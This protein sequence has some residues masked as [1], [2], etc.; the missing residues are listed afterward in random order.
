ME[1]FKMDKLLGPIPRTKKNVIVL[2]PGICPP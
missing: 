2:T 1:V